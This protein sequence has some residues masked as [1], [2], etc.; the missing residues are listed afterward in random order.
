MPG[1]CI[2]GKQCLIHSFA[3]NYRVIEWL[4]RPFLPR[5]ERKQIELVRELTIIGN[6]NL[7]SIPAC[8]GEFHTAKSIDHSFSKQ[9][10]SRAIKEGYPA[11][12]VENSP[13]TQ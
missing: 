5:E 3:I 1:C 7:G 2:W 11:K 6:G 12:C 8:E 9:H 13:L 10:N 4:R